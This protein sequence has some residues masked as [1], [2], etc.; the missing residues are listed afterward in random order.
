M[1]D[2]GTAGTKG[3]T[4]TSRWSMYIFGDWGTAGI[5]GTQSRL[6]AV[7]FINMLSKSTVR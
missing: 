3:T 2:W 5:E 1:G 4:I 7:F 6:S